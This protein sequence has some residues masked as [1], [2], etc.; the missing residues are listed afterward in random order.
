MPDNFQGNAP[1]LIAVVDGAT[2]I[3]HHRRAGDGRVPHYEITSV[4]CPLGHPRRDEIMTSHG[5]RFRGDAQTPR[6][7]YPGMN[8]LMQRMIATVPMNVRWDDALAP[9]LSDNSPF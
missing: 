6:S 4:K 9:D 7:N 3:A 1:T 8:E 2:F 5:K